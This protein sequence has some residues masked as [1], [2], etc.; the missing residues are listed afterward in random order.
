MPLWFM[1]TLVIFA[2][3]ASSDL[4]QARRLTK[5]LQFDE[6]ITLL[7]GVRAVPNLD[8]A[9]RAQ[10][11]QLLAFCQVAV[12]KRPDAVD[13]FAE[14]LKLEPETDLDRSLVSPKVLDVFVLAKKQVF[15]EQSASLSEISAGPRFLALKAVD[16]WKL[17]NQIRLHFRQEHMAWTTAVLEK[18][19]GVYTLPISAERETK[20]EWYAQAVG[21]TGEVLASIGTADVP[22]V[23]LPVVPARRLDRV[24]ISIRTPEPVPAHR[25]V[26]AVVAGLAVVTAGIGAGFAANAYSTRLAARDN[27]RA[28]GDWADTARAAEIQAFVDSQWAAAL[29]ISAGGAGAL[30]AGMIL[31]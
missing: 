22:K 14:L 4:A 19:E 10:V 29:F 18:V 24:A 15:G 31:W 9:E 11:L 30:G 25:I 20:L 12:G 8:K 5:A 2:Q 13:S 21:K 3:T 1:T 16:P 23:I 28:P 7:E 27:T 6:A 17:V 26:G